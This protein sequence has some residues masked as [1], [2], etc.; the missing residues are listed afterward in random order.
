MQNALIVVG[1][2]AFP[3]AVCWFA[4]KGIFEAGVIRQREKERLLAEKRAARQKGK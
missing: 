4:W 3:I 2:I 1:V